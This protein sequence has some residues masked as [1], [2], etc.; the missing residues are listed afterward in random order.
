M[1]SPG[2]RR[3]AVRR[4]EGRLRRGK[5]A[6]LASDGSFLRR[7]KRCPRMAARPDA[8]MM[9][10]ALTVIAAAAAGSGRLLE[11]LAASG[12]AVTVTPS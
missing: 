5:I 4:F 2:C 7:L 8:S 1:R 6:T 9:A 3:R 12:C 10:R 11:G